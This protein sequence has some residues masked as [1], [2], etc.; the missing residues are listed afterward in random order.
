MQWKTENCGFC[1]SFLDFRRISLSQKLHFSSRLACLGLQY[2]AEPAFP[3]LKFQ[4]HLVEF[5]K[6]IEKDEHRERFFRQSTKIPCDECPMAKCY[7]F[8]C[9]EVSLKRIWGAQDYLPTWLDHAARNDSNSSVEDVMIKHNISKSFEKIAF[10]WIIAFPFVWYLS[11]QLSSHIES[12]SSPLPAS[13]QRWFL[14]CKGNDEHNFHTI[15][16][17]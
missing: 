9:M 1:E 11:Q 12:A 14:L 10:E 16:T 17:I 15:G 6:S 13:C 4:K 2:S 5:S 3:L 8:S 7:T